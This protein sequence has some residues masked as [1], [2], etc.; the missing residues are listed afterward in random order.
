MPVPVSGMPVIRNFFLNKRQLNV[1][2]RVLVVLLLGTAL[3]VE[4]TDN[5]HLSQI[6]ST[7]M[8]RISGGNSDWLMGTLALM[9]LN[10]FAEAAKW[11]PFI[12]RYEPISWRKSFFAVM[13]GVTFALF[14][15]NRVGEYAGRLLFVRRE[16]HWKALMA[17]VLGSFAQLIILLSMG[18]LGGLWF[19]LNVSGAS[20]WAL[21]AFV[22]AILAIGLLYAAF[23]N[24]KTLLPLLKR[25]P[26]IRRMKNMLRDAEVLAQAERKTLAAVLGWSAFRYSVYVTQY[27]FLLQFFHIQTGITAGYAG[28]ATIFLLQ[29]IIPLPAVAALLLRGNL[30]IFIWSNFSSDEAGILAATFL[31][32]IIN[33]ILPALLGTFSLLHVRIAKTLGYEND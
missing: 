13:T 3:Y 29:T 28:I 10:W 24:I 19:V 9:P 27:F 8:R 22:L 4:S 1:G 23:F 7:C 15:P 16:N 25:I 5:Q 33:L 21:P 20:A 12:K 26:Y 32:W 2:F 6:G 17:N 18:L 30:A 11:R 14:T 31:L